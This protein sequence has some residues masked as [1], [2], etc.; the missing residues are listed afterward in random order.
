MRLRSF[1]SMC[2]SLADVYWFWSRQ[3]PRSGRSPDRYLRGNRDP[4][5]FQARPGGRFPLG[6]ERR[7]G[8]PGMHVRR[9][10]LLFAI[11]LGLAAMAAALSQSRDARRVRGAPPGET[12][13]RARPAE[14]PG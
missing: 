4:G 14:A 10:L 9:A 11:V 1:R 5:C 12:R 8:W 7:L 3:L 6:E 2:S 13:V